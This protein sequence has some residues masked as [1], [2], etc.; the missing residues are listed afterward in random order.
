MFGDVKVKGET[1]HD[2]NFGWRFN[3][4][5]EFHRW[6]WI[7]NALAAREERVAVMG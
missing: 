5:V 4:L 1:F 7:V 3:D 6:A 2:F